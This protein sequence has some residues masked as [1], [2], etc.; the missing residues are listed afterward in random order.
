MGAPSNPDVGPLQ[1]ARQPIVWQVTR[2]CLNASICQRRTE[3]FL[4]GEK[5]EK[6][7]ESGVGRGVTS[8]GEKGTKDA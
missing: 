6:G 3:H 1:R 8:K 4:R 7:A 5:G 2:V